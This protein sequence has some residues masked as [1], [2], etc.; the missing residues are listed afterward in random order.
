VSVVKT[1][2]VAFRTS[3]IS[4]CIA[5]ASSAFLP[6]AWAQNPAKPAAPAK[7]T[8]KIEAPVIECEP[9]TQN[10]DR[11]L[12]KA[13]GGVSATTDEL[14][15]KSREMTASAGK[16]GGIE[17]MHAVG[18]VVIKGSRKTPDG[19]EQRLD[20]TSDEATYLASERVLVLEGNVKGTLVE[21]ERDRTWDLT[22]RRAR[23]WLDES[24]L[25]LEGASITMTM[26]E[27]PEKAENK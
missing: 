23:I 12:C 1:G 11:Q 13:S 5:L 24:R 25:R 9:D 15:I 17:Q 14:S 10:P 18:G 27:K 16:K 22:S 20:A 7:R 19:V 4:A 8:M 3:R 6:A 2:S 21:V 26:P